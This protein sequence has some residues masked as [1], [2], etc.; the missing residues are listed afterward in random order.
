MAL[1]SAH[2]LVCGLLIAAVVKFPAKLEALLQLLL[3]LLL[4]PL[5]QSMQF[6]NHQQVCDPLSSLSPVCVDIEADAAIRHRF[7]DRQQRR[8]QLG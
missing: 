7:A 8:K 4:Q 5:L 1:G 6:P 3:Q 2:E